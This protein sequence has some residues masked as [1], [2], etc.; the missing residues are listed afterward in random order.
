MKVVG[1]QGILG[2]YSEVVAHRLF[3]GQKIKVKGFPT[4]EE[5]FKAVET[6]RISYGVVPIENSLAGSIHENYDHLMNHSVS[7][8]HEHY[9][10][11]RH[12]LLGVQ[13]AS[14]KSIKK[15]YS[16]PQAL[17]QCRSFLSAKEWEAVPYF[18]TAGSAKFVAA[19]GDPT[20]AAIAGAHASEDYGLKILRNSI[21]DDKKNY[22]RFFVIQ[23]GGSKVLKTSEAVCK[24][25][26]CFALKNVAGCLHKCLSVFAIRD[27]DLYKIESRPQ[28][29]SPWVYL[30]YLDFKGSLEDETVKRCLDHLSEITTMIKVLGS[31]AT[32]KM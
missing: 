9:L 30:F 11:V 26:I 19:S 29:G 5:V 15:V 7:I 12:A 1:F 3:E 31:Y 14:L 10:R 27:I 16:H 28:K 32:A 21:E 25:S 8:T 6:K 4:F 18:D 13:E 23:P 20:C 17:Q 24:T 2:A 22:T